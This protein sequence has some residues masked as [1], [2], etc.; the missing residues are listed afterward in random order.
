MQLDLKF[1]YACI[2][3]SVAFIVL[4]CMTLSFYSMRL[5]AARKTE[6]GSSSAPDEKNEKAAPAWKA[7]AQP[8]ADVKPRHVAAIT[9]A[10]LAATKG[11]GRIISI[12]PAGRASFL[13]TTRRWRAAAIVEAAGRRLAPSWK[14]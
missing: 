9:A 7:P 14:R 8:A 5:L 6:G 1:I 3:F 13:D 4:G 2:S 12:V 11:R 10:I